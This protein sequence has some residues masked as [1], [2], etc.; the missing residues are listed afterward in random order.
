MERDSYNIL[1]IV[2]KKECQ[3]PVA[4][5][6]SL[7]E[8]RFILAY[9]VLVFRWLADSKTGWH[10]TGQGKGIIPDVMSSRKQREN[11]RRSGIALPGHSPVTLLL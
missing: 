9:I 2:S 11:P 4:N 8:E 5:T 6:H 7:Q 1:R 10:G 3:F